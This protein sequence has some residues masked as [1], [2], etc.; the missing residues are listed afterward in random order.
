MCSTHETL[1][2]IHSRRTQTPHDDACAL[3]LDQTDARYRCTAANLFYVKT[4]INWGFEDFVYC[5]RSAWDVSAHDCP[6]DA[7]GW[8]SRHRKSRRDT[9]RVESL[10]GVPR[11]R[12]AHRIPMKDVIPDVSGCAGGSSAEF[13][14][15]NLELVVCLGRRRR[16][17]APHL[18]LTRELVT[19][20]HCYGTSIGRCHQHRA[21][22][23]V[24]GRGMSFVYAEYRSRE[25]VCSLE[26]DGSPACV[27]CNTYGH[28]ANYL[29]CPCASKKYPH[30]YRNSKDKK[31]S[32]TDKAAPGRAPARAVSKNISYDNVTAGRRKDP[33]KTN[34]DVSMNT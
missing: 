20:E 27:L 24:C 28:T 7:T 14:L 17:L 31:N 32:P 18:E 1:D 5:G 6:M 9:A 23:G 12:E 25:S 13:V 22:V 33:P 3:T 16:R 30:P 34:S 11:A 10:S 21:R 26:T 4:P 19:C 15:Q 29:G 8:V 2:E